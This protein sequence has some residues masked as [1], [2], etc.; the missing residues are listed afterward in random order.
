MISTPSRTPSHGLRTT[1]KQRG[2]GLLEVLLFIAVLSGLAVTGYLEW[3]ARE[4]VKTARQERQSLSQADTALITF[5]TIH[6]RLPCPD[7]NRDGLEDCGSTAQKGW[8]PSTTLQLAGADPGVS[9][10]QLR[11]L[12]QRGATAYDLANPTI[13]DDWRPLEYDDGSPANF[14]TMRTTTA[15]GGDYQADILTLTDLCQRLEV[16]SGTALSSGMAQVASSP[17]RTVAYALVHPGISDADGN[18]SLFEGINSTGSGNSVE[19]PA[20]TPLLSSYDDRVLERSFSSLYTAFNCQPLFQSIN[21]VA[22]GLDVIDQVADM[23][24]DSIDAAERA[25]IF[26]SLATAITA[27]ELSAAIIE[28]ASDAGNA[29]ADGVICGASLGLAVNACAAVGIHV[30]AAVAAGVSSAASIA[31]I[32]LNATAAAA[33]GAALALAD[34]TADAGD[35]TASCPSVDL[36]ASLASSL[37]E[38]NR[39]KAETIALQNELT[40]KQ[41]QLAPSIAA[42]NTAYTNLRNA[43]RY[44]GSAYQ[45]SIDYRVDNLNN[46]ATAWYNNNQAVLVAEAQVTAYSDAVTSGIAQ[47]AD[48]DAQIADRAGTAAAL[49]A[50]IAVIDAD[51]AALQPDLNSSNPLVVAA[52]EDSLEA[53]ELERVKASGKLALVSN[54]TSL[55]QARDRAASDLLEAQGDL[56]AA[57]AANNTAQTAIG[58]SKTAYQNAY[59]SLISA[60]YGPYTIRIANSTAPDYYASYVVCTNPGFPV[61]CTVAEGEPTPLQTVVQVRSSVEA[62]YGGFVTIGLIPVWFT[63]S[64]Q[65]VESSKFLAPETIQKEIDA[66]QTRVD[67]AVEIESTAKSNYDDLLAQSNNPPACNITGTGVTP[68]SPTSAADLL[69]NVDI[70][71]GTR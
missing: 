6:F 18:D 66:L 36:S 42:R 8:L 5:S 29:V 38:W 39:A 34:D 52:A 16:G 24:E 9:T 47:V 25:V 31:T 19:D 33:A 64:D 49:E 45:S 17:A 56:A 23:R 21:T 11:Y 71:G 51:I 22:L 40:A 27:V 41:A 4:T 53:L 26:A 3:R 43:V 32:A 20:K 10:G 60:A 62:L 63:G 12:V 46:A 65:P 44:Y 15:S 68:W 37:A 54:P 1:A 48:Y 67:D 7:T 58:S 14:N 59:S 13:A 55:Q 61:P 57:V 35:L 50:E 28:A 2:L 30:G 70:K 69:L